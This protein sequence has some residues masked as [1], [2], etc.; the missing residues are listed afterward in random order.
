M[1]GELRTGN[2]DILLHRTAIK[3]LPKHMQIDYAKH[4]RRASVGTT[5][6]V[7]SQRGG[8]Q[9]ATINREELAQFI[10]DT[11]GKIFTATF[12]KKDNSVRNMNCRKGVH[13][14]THGGTNK[15]AESHKN[16]NIVFDM[17]AHEYRMINMETVTKIKFQKKE[18]EVV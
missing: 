17:Q 1:Y 14:F 11:G 8:H 15:A 12:V 9:M 13:A 4:S 3:N 6:S 16:L 10:K 18:Y 2:H 7:T 5:N